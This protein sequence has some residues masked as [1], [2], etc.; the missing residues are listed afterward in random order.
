MRCKILKIQKLM[1]RNIIRSI[2]NKKTSILH[3]T[4]R[5]P[6]R[7]TKNELKLNLKNY[8]SNYDFYC[9]LYFI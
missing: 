6:M 4:S 3:Y 5:K 1:W 2:K 8:W 9:L 7:C